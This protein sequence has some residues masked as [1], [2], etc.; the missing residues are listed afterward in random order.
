MSYSLIIIESPSK[1]NKI[2]S[3]LGGG[4]KCV[5]T[6]GHLCSLSSLESINVD[7]NFEPTYELDPKKKK[8]I[9]LLRKLIKE[10]REVILAT[11]DDREGE[12]IAWHICRIFSLPICDTKRILFH[13]ITEAA[14][15]SAI[16]HPKRINMN[17][18]YAQQS[19]QILDILIGFHISPILW[20]HINRG[21]NL[22][23]GRCQTPAL[24][25]VWENQKEIDASLNKVFYKT[26]GYFTGKAIQFELTTQFENKMDVN[27]FLDASKMAKHVF[28]REEPKKIKR[29]PPSPLSTSRIQQLAS[30]LM[31]ISPKETMKYCQTLYEEGL[32]T[33][34]RTDSKQY[35]SEF[36]DCAKKYILDKYDSKYIHPNIDLL[37]L[38]ENK[39]K[40]GGEKEKE[41]D[42]T[43]KERKTKQNIN[44]KTELIVGA[45]EAIRPT[46]ILLDD[47]EKVESKLTAREKKLYKLI[48]QTSLQSCMSPQE[49]SVLHS[50]I[51]ISENPYLST[52]KYKNTSELVEFDG[53]TLIVG[54][55]TSKHDH[56]DYNYL[57]NLKLETVISWKRILAKMG[58]QGIKSHIGEAGLVQ[59][60]ED[61]GIGRPSTY[62]MLVDK[63]QERKY[64][65][66]EDVKGKDIDC[67]DYSLDFGELI[68][69]QI[70]KRIVG[71]EK[72]KL[73]LQPLGQIVMEFIDKH[74]DVL[75]DYEYTKN[76]EDELDKISAG[77][78]PWPEVCRQCFSLLLEIEKKMKEEK[79]I[80]IKIDEQHSYIIGKNGPVIKCVELDGQIVFKE[81][82][83]NLDIQLLKEGKYK[84]EDVL[85][86]KRDKV[87]GK[88][89]DKEVVL[90]K[91][92]YGL[93]AVVD[94]ETN[95]S[96]S[97][98]G[99]R[100]LENI[101]WDEI[102]P[103]LEDKM[104]CQ[105]SENLE[106][107][108]HS[109]GVIRTINK[110]MSI[111]QGK[112]G[113][114][115][116]YK[117]AK[118][119]KPQFLKIHGFNGNYKTCDVSLL[120]EWINKTYKI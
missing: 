90:K 24:R 48:W 45:H 15:Q 36:V 80:E 79:K 13:E 7:K 82:K 117:T 93:Y 20:S 64:V 113:P 110:E 89:L 2:E 1:C 73:V 95:I 114:Y 98:F 100:P 31:H 105:V 6:F 108:I 46:N 32:I 118:M 30:N 97:K 27:S 25:L 56:K 101:S 49:C 106:S 57:I 87:I 43:K 16:A 10:S 18:V 17:L 58:V 83:S 29:E 62:A 33:Y 44:Q 21:S 59:L 75:F 102:L 23:A 86:E 22:S 72:R 26:I 71:N 107:D 4:Y 51:N 41:K 104:S 92:K 115:I 67:Y 81:V 119:A 35:C 3:F 99:N 53:W 54:E 116:F 8:N 63:I 68:V 120:L 66:Q 37:V 69:E 111:R 39:E 70:E 77:Q 94:G 12:A 74:I 65:I 11:D 76:M 42:K 9:E 84:L 96:L 47:L 103:L 88:Y 78:V 40:E 91:G 19:R 38:Q 112:Y 50:T 109:I 52:F 14:I 61:R 85:Q 55:P 60:L 28:H 34:M 5:A